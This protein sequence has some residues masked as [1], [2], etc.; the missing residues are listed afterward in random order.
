MVQSAILFFT[1]I[2]PVFPKENCPINDVFDQ[3]LDWAA[4][5]NNH[6]ELIHFIA[7]TNGPYIKDLLNKGAN[8]D[9]Q[10]GNGNT[11]LHLAAFEGHNYIA[12]E[13]LKVGADYNIKNN[14]G[15]V[16]NEI[17]NF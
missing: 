16:P 4:K 10:D 2:L 9:V 12:K 1:L 7:K 17:A 14:A 8:V 11:A 6:Q 13:L 5:N 3:V 15:K